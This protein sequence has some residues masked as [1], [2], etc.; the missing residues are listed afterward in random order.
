LIERGHLQEVPNA[1]DGRFTLLELTPAG[2]AICDRG[3]PA[4]HRALTRIDEALAGRLDEHEEVVWRI[5]IALQGRV[6][7]WEPQPGG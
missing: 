2:Q 5:R 7:E 3:K 4:F 1:R 6:T